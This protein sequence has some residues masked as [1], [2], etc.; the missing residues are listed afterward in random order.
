[1]LVTPCSP[2]AHQQT[3]TSLQNSGPPWPS[4]SRQL[5]VAGLVGGVLVL[6][7]GDWMSLQGGSPVE[8]SVHVLSTAL[9]RPVIEAALYTNNTCQADHSKSQTRD[10]E[11][12]QNSSSYNRCTAGMHYKA[13]SMALTIPPYCNSEDIKGSCLSQV[14][15][16]RHPQTVI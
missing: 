15:D 6:A 2:R 14:L 8:D 9:A 5:V 3:A 7:A 11:R 16:R 10:L 13:V 4:S 1:M 12:H